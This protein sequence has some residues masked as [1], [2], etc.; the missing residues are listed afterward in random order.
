[1]TDTDTDSPP[2]TAVVTFDGEAADADRAELREAVDAFEQATE[3]LAALGVAVQARVEPDGL[4][5][6][7]PRD[8]PPIQLPNE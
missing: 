3:R 6:H 5:R 7:R 1:M 2:L 4:A 8:Q